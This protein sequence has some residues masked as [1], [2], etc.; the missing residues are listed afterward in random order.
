MPIDDPS[1]AL[2]ALNDAEERSQFLPQKVP[3]TTALGAIFGV[4]AAATTGADAVACATAAGFLTVAANI[5]ASV[6]ERRQRE[7]VSCLHDEFRRRSVTPEMLEEKLKSRDED[8]HE[9]LA[10]AVVRASEAKSAERVRRIAHLLTTIIFSSDNLQVEEARVML[11]IAGSLFDM[12]AFAL[13]RMYDAQHGD[14][15]RRQGHPELNDITATWRKLREGHKEFREGPINSSCSRLQSHGLVMRV[16]PGTGQFDLQ[17]Y[18]YAI[19]E[20]GIRFYKWCL[21][22]LN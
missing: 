1:S 20:F 22:D 10:E 8:F 13:G 19:T 16:E 9:L 2:A 3:I 18:V 7:F 21:K 12:D 11:E 6:G 14:I 5:V 17:T 15:E 4:V